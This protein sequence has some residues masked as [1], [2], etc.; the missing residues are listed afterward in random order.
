MSKRAASPTL[1]PP[2]RRRDVL[3]LGAAV[4]SPRKCAARAVERSPIP[5]L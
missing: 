5:S 3:N 4:T 2:Q 1:P